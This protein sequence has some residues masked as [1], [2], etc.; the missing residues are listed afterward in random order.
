MKERCKICKVV[1]LISLTISIGLIIGGFFVPPKGVIDGSVL[2]ACGILF[3][4]AALAV[5]SHAI[6]LGYDLKFQKGDAAIE[7]H[8]D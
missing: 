3:A 7:I 2:T 1:F 4:F 6:E 5:G 8:N